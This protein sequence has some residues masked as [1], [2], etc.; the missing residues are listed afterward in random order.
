MGTEDEGACV[1]E[2]EDL[3]GLA[4]QHIGFPY[5]RLERRLPGIRR[6]GS[7]SVKPEASRAGPVL[8]AL[9]T[10]VDS[11]FAWR[12]QEGFPRASDF[13]AITKDRARAPA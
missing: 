12:N 7:H 10:D 2:R 3:V 5:F 6:G 4:S 8:A 13:V 9:D 1:P 11:V